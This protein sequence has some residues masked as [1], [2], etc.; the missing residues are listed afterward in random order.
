M[1]QP[2]VT[3]E[4]LQTLRFDRAPAYHVSHAVIPGSSR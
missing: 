1:D 3:G 2:S 4:V